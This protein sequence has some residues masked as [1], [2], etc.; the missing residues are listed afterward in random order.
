MTDT[1]EV[2]DNSMGFDTKNRNDR[3]HKGLVSVY[4]T[5]YSL[6]GSMKLNSEIGQGTEIIITM[7]MKGKRSYES[8]ISR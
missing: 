8:F 4:D 2:L 6:E 3:L 5:V 1:L 7:Q